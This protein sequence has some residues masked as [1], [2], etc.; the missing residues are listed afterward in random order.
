MSGLR[1]LCLLLLLPLTACTYGPEEEHARVQ[2]VALN[3]DAKLAAAIVI[4][5]RY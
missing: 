5:Q 3:P 1:I 4:Y 2:N